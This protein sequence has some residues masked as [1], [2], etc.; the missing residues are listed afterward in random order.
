MIDPK[1]VATLRDQSL[2]ELKAAHDYFAETVAAWGIVAEV[3]TTGRQ[4]IHTNP[5]AGTVVT[6]TEL[7]RKSQGYITKQLA[8]ATFQQFIAVFENFLFDFLRL[9]LTAYPKSLGAKTVEFRRIL[10]APDKEA[11]TLQVVN[12]ELNEVMYERPAEWFAYLEAKAKL[13]CPSAD[14]IERFAEAK[15]SRDILVHNR[16]VVNAAYRTK[17]GRLARYEAGEFIDIP[18]PYHHATWEL[19]NTLVASIADA[20]LGKSP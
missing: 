9:W 18:D 11:I 4:F 13:G 3:V 8:E 5:P 16:G 15:A 6:E 12:H 20:A 10:D 1:A 19:L 2:D 7:V 14:L 17:A